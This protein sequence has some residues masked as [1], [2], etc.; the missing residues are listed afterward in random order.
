MAYQFNEARGVIGNTTYHGA[1]PSQA[2]SGRVIG[3]TGSAY[4]ED[5][6]GN[7][8]DA[9]NTAANKTIIEDPD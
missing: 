3:G 6:L 8:R 2:V 4:Y 9:V 1:L 5:Y 7:I